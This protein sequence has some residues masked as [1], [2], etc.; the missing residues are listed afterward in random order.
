MRILEDLIDA[1]DYIAK[2]KELLFD[3]GSIVLEYKLLPETVMR[4]EKIINMQ[5]LA[6][7]CLEEVT[8]MVHAGGLVKYGVPP[9]AIGDSSISINDDIFGDSSNRVDED[10]IIDLD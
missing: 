1:R 6:D 7:S 9:H 10:E 3:V 4:I 2:S 8:G 5:N